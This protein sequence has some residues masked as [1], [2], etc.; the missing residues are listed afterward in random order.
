MDRKQQSDW[1]SRAQQLRDIAAKWPGG[2]LDLIA[3]KV[4]E[5][6]TIYEDGDF[7]PAKLRM[8]KED[9]RKACRATERETGLDYF[10]AVK[11]LK[12][13]N[14]EDKAGYW[15]PVLLTFDQCLVIAGDLLANVENCLE[16]VDPF[17][18]MVE[19]VHGIRPPSPLLIWPK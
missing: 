1:R 4:F 11:D 5:D 6:G 7:A 12:D 16:K 19:V 2:N 14:N 3:K 17:L 13:P 10:Y 15:Q 9:L 18:D 8:V